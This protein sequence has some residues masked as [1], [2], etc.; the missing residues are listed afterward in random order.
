[1]PKPPFDGLACAG[2]ALYAAGAATMVCAM[3]LLGRFW[4]VKLVLAP[5]HRLQ[6]HPLFRLVRHPN[7]YLGILP[8]LADLALAFQAWVILRLVLILYAVPL[9]LRIQQEEQVMRER[10]RFY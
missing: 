3:R 7:Y 1:M 6:M 9:T 5:D 10:F 4:T 8:E 2:I